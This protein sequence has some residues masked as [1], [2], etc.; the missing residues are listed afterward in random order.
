MSKT[1]T[2]EYLNFKVES[3]SILIDDVDLGTLG[4]NDVRRSVAVIPQDPTLFQGTLRYNLDP[5]GRH[6]DE[7]IW[8]A[9]ER[10][11]L[12]EKVSSGGKQLSAPV[13]AEGENFSVGEKQLICLAR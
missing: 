1:D 4:L 10:A 2:H 7:D 8:R 3:G 13:D 11:H 6:K 5:F 12:K 9:L